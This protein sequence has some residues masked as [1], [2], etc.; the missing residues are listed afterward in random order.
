MTASSLLNHWFRCAVICTTSHHR[1]L[2]RVCYIIHVIVWRPSAFVWSKYKRD[3]TIRL[4][5]RRLDIA[6]TWDIVGRRVSSRRWR[7][8]CSNNYVFQWFFHFLFQNFGSVES[9]RSF[10]CKSSSHCWNKFHNFNA[11][12]ATQLVTYS[13][14]SLSPNKLFRI[15]TSYPCTVWRTF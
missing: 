13:K 10:D 15:D 4:L 8:E 2:G 12:I 11:P 3:A 7:G 1:W 14:T 5:L 6:A 9:N